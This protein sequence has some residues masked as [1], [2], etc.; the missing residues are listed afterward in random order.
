MSPRPP[1]SRPFYRSLD[2]LLVWQQAEKRPI[3]WAER[4]GRRAPL[5]L[6]IGTGNGEFLARCA[7]D[8]PERDFVG[9]EMRWASVK[10]ALRNVARAAAGNVRL[11]IEDARP[12]VERLFAPRSLAQ[13]YVLFPCP[14]RKEKHAQHRLLQRPFLDV[15][16]NRLV[17]GGELLLVTDWTPLQEWTLAQLPGSGLRAETRDIG[18][19]FDTKYERKWSS[20]GTRRFHEIRLVKEEHRD[21]PPPEEPPLNPPHLATFDLD[22][23]EPREEIGPT[24]ITFK[25]VVRDRERGLLMVRTVV[26][27]GSLTQHVWITVARAGDG[28]WWIVPSRG[29][30]T[31]PTAGVQRALDLLAGCA[32]T[33]ATG[34]TAAGGGAGA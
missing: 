19:R 1:D 5:A 21:V 27:E 3:D 22:R 8:H 14:W 17:D 24:T 12:V 4:F 15:L 2:P 32:A 25:E 20:L 30:A 6:E 11:V 34:A 26:I 18:P 16:N 13:I 29:C 7:V 28:S 9:V 33:T 31:V 10:R 23:F